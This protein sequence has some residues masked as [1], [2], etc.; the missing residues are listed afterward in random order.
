LIRFQY[1]N[2]NTS[3]LLLSS[4]V[5]M[6]V[7]GIAMVSEEALKCYYSPAFRWKMVL[8]AAAVLF[9]FTF[10]RKAVLDSSN[11]TELKTRIVDIS[12]WLGVGIAGR[13]I[14]LI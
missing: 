9:Y 6:V 13:A 4:L 3:R 10:H 2:S 1:S 5:V 11:T 8:L 7:S 14:G 12:L